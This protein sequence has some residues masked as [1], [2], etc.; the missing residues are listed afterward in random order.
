MTSDV[1]RPVG[2]V[3]GS[4]TQPDAG[5]QER[6]Q[7]S[8]GAARIKI[9]LSAHSFGRAAQNARLLL[10]TP[11]S[12]QSTRLLGR[13]ELYL[14][15]LKAAQDGIGDLAVHLHVAFEGKGE[16]VRRFGWGVVGEMGVMGIMGV[17]SFRGATGQ[18]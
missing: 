16:G 17:M 1:I 13:H 8:W 18:V 5:A 2:R 11:G 14:V 15:L 9:I 6:G 12:L 3:G 7:Q 10:R 4:A